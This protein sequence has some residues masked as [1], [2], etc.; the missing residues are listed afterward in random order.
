MFPQAILFDLDDTIIS[1]NHASERAWQ[2]VCCFFVANNQ[3][4]FDAG[5]L[6]EAMNRVKNWYWS[7]PERHR[8]GRLNMNQARLD[9]PDRQALI[10]NPLAVAGFSARETG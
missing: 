3:A 2:Q 6:L 4:P 8:T 1:Y 5:T 7:D 10:E 9:T